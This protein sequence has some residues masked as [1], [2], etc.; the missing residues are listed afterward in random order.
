MK[1]VSVERA[2][3]LAEVRG[4]VLEVGFGTG[5]NL[6]HYPAGVEAVVGVDPSGPNAKLARKRIARA[7]FPVE[8][9]PLEAERIA[10][11]DA[12]FDSVVFTFSLCTIADPRAALLQMRRV[13]K[14]DG[15]LFFLEHGRSDEPKVQRW[16]ERL[17]G[18]QRRIFGGCN[19]NREIDRLVAD[20]G[21]AIDALERYYVK[22]P[23][24]MAYYYRG[25]AHRQA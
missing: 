21:F 10:A 14:P 1:A 9:V 17:N 6:P 18:L 3:C 19:L 5:L 8:F 7:A 4:R 23:K 22:G 16:Q 25:V 15:R 20:A 24:A 12:S 11:P 2:R 13:L